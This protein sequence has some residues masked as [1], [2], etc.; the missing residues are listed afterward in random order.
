M[1][2]LAKREIVM[3]QL[4]TPLTNYKN[5]GG[6]FAL[7]N[8]AYSGLNRDAWFRLLGKHQPHKDNC[9]FVAIPDIVGNARRTVEL[10]Y[11][12]TQDRRTHF[13]DSKWALVAQDGLEDQRIEWN[14]VRWLFIGGTDKFKD[15]QACYDIVKT[16]KALDIPV[17][18][19]RVNQ[20]KRFRVYEELGADTCDGSSI[21]M[22]D[23]KLRDIEM[24]RDR[25]RD[26]TP[27]FDAMTAQ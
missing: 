11:Y 22:Y 25:K 12:I 19:G 13:W 9:L 15:S 27:M 5:W 1:Q 10:Y 4:C 18:V 23:Y 6:V 7:D 8:G 20:I 3:G 16:A 21:A 24:L 2:E 14:G 26:E 17:H